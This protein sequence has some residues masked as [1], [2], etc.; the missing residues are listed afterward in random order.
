MSPMAAPLMK[1]NWQAAAAHIGSFLLVIALFNYYSKA[2]KHAVAQTFRYKLFN[3]VTPANGA[4]CN[5]NGAALPGNFSGQC[6]TDP[7]YAPPKKSLKFNSITGV[8]LFFAIT[9]FAHIFYATDG[10]GSGSYSAAVNAGWNPYRWLEYGAS[11]SIMTVLI[12]YQL[13]IRD[14]NHLTSLVF[15]NLAMQLCGFLVENSLIQPSINAT[16]VNG[17]TAA[18]W[19]LFMGMWA[20]ILY[21]FW[22]IVSDVNTIFEGQV[23]PAGSPAVGKPIKIPGFVW[24]IIFSQV[25]NFGGFGIV[26]WGQT[27]DALAGSPKPFS[28][29]ESRYLTLSFAGKLALASGI[30]YGLLFRTRNCP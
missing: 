15:I 1:K 5:S 18:G 23:E 26:Q 29:Y 7:V 20:P 10:F 3:P 17:A 14:T 19:L 4:A 12:A 6:D 28:V 24:F 25:I 30:A 8:L 21:A 27:R 13:G 22:T 2:Q 11:A 16:A 9:A